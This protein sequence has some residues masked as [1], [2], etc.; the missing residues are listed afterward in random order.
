MVNHLN[1]MNFFLTHTLLFIFC[2][3]VQGASVEFDKV[4]LNTFGKIDCSPVVKESTSVGLYVQMPKKIQWGDPL[5][6]C[7]YLKVD[8]KDRNTSLSALI[9]LIRFEPIGSQ[10][11]RGINLDTEFLRGDFSG[12]NTLSKQS[13]VYFNVNGLSNLVNI[14]PGEF[15]ISFN[16][17]NHPFLTKPQRLTIEAS[18]W[19]KDYSQLFVKALC[20]DHLI[21]DLGR[22]FGD[23][24]KIVHKRAAT[25]EIAQHW[26]KDLATLWQNEI[27]KHPDLISDS[28]YEQLEKVD[29]LD[30]TIPYYVYELI[31][32]ECPG[33]KIELRKIDSIFSAIREYAPSRRSKSLNK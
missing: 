24:N 15:D 25:K 32:K 21:E 6:I 27:S 14:S 13:E 30:E 33:Q 28:T 16:L 18:G 11:L 7:G 19:R 3:K 29:R 31:Q 8:H 9:R 23:L 22:Y 2:L 1:K 5:P 20:K 4:K 17:L 10:K 26:R 12:Q